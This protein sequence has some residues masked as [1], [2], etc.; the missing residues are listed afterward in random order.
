MI[1][2]TLERGLIS[3][4]EDGFI[5][6]LAIDADR[7]IGSRAFS[8]L[9]KHRLSATQSKKRNKKGS[10]EKVS[11]L[12]R[13]LE[14]LQEF[15]EDEKEVNHVYFFVRNCAGERN[16]LLT[17]ENTKVLDVQGMVELLNRQQQ[18]NGLNGRQLSL[19]VCQFYLLR[20]RLFY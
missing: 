14:Y 10:P 5:Y 18:D 8:Y 9:Y 19:L 2:E 7:S 16:G 20:H 11:I 12:L 1:F 17:E 13:V 3:A 6:E 15:A 4:E